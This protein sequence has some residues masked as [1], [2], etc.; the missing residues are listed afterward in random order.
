MSGQFIVADKVIYRY[1]P[2]ATRLNLVFGVLSFFSV[3]FV[4]Q[5]TQFAKYF[6]WLAISL[7]EFE[8]ISIKLN[9][10]QKY[11]QNNEIS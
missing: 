11:K 5:Y 10:H 4:C 2:A 8:I 6:G 9:G 1:S 3:D 7:G